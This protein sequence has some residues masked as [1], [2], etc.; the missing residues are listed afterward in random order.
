MAQVEA[1]LLALPSVCL[2][3]VFSK[4]SR[5]ELFTASLVCHALRWLPANQLEVLVI[6]ESLSCPPEQLQHMR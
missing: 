2:D 6:D 3:H 1:G 4:L 5:E